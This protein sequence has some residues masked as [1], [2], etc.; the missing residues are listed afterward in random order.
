MRKR[1]LLV[2]CII[3]SRVKGSPGGKEREEEREEAK[4]KTSNKK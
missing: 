4:R 2:L 3:R 1:Q